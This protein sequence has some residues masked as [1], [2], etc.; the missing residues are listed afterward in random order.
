M[1][2]NQGRRRVL[3]TRHTDL[4]LPDDPSAVDDGRRQEGVPAGRAGLAV[5]ML[6]FWHRLGRRASD[7]ASGPDAGRGAI[8][9]G[10]K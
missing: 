1:L 2:A 6:R 4:G 9:D 8:H 3:E 10:A 5:L 7:R